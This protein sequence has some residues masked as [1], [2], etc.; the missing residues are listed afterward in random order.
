MVSADAILNCE[1]CLKV[2]MCH[3]AFILN[4]P[5]LKVIKNKKKTWSKSL[6][7]RQ[8]KTFHYRTI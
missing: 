6:C 5:Y 3:H 7:F 2:T 4:K 1:S 8:K